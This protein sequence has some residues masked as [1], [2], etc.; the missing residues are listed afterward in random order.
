[1]A[2]FININ[3]CVFFEIGF[4]FCF[5]WGWCID[6]VLRVNVCRLLRF[7]EADMPFVADSVGGFGPC[8]KQV[9][10]FLVRHARNDQSHE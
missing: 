6:N 8:A 10:D 5:F 9:G 3:K 4:C 7:F 1:M 2:P